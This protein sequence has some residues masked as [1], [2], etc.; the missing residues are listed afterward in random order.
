MAYFDVHDSI[1]S[2]IAKSLEDLPEEAR[3]YLIDLISVML[4]EFDALRESD[5]GEECRQLRSVLRGE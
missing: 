1:T 5:W 2:D 3:D 4:G